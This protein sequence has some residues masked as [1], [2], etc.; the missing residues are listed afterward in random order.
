MRRDPRTYLWDASRAAGLLDDFSRG[1]S[2]ADYQ[3]DELLKSAV[4]RQF[5]VVGEA[6]NQLSK[7]APEM[8]HPSRTCGGS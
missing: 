7:A 2:F 1:K 4:E 6:L 3:S 5:E 8:A